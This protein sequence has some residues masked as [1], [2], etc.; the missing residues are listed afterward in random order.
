MTALAMHVHILYPA[1]KLAKEN[2]SKY[3]QIHTYKAG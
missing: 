3:N 2:R 1:A